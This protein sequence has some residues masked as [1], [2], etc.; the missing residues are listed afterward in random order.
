[1]CRGGAGAPVWGGVVSWHGAAAGSAASRGRALPGVDFGV[2]FGLKSLES[3]AKH[4][5]FP[6]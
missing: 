1:M 2:F 6:P 3:I 4:Q 5:R